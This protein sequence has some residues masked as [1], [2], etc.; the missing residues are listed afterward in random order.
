[1]KRLLIF[2]ALLLVVQIA[3]GVP[4]STEAPQPYWTWEAQYCASEKNGGHCKWIEG[5]VFS[6]LVVQPD[7]EPDDYCPGSRTVIQGSSYN[8]LNTVVEVSPSISGKI[9][10][11]SCRVYVLKEDED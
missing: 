10:P 7:D 11:G 4:D 5:D 6:P 3:C 8:L 9:V 1:M 2:F